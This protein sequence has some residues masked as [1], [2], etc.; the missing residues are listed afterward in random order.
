MVLGIEYRTMQNLTGSGVGQQGAPRGGKLRR[1]RLEGKKD[2][3]TDQVAV[4]CQNLFGYVALCCLHRGDDT[5][6]EQ[7]NFDSNGAG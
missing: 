3:I 2:V 1:K 5:S 4:L 7:T 6:V